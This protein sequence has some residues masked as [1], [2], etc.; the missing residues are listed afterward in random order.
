MPITLALLLSAIATGLIGVIVGFPALRLKG[1]YLAMATLG[2]GEMVRSFF[3]NLP[4]TGGSGGF[5]GMK[6]VSVGYMWMWA[7]AS[8]PQCSCWRARASGS[9]CAPSMTTKRRQTSSDS[10]SRAEGRCLRVRRGNR[11]DCRWPLRPSSSL[12]RAGNFGFERSIELVIAVILGGSTV[13][14][15][16]LV[17]GAIVVLLPEYLRF[18]AQWR[19]AAFGD[20]SRARAVDTSAGPHRQAGA[21]VVH[22]LGEGLTPWRPSATASSAPLLEVD[23]VTRRFGGVTAL[24][25]VSLSVPEGRIVG[26]IG[27]NGAGKTTVFNVI[28]GAYPPS[29]GDVRFLG[30]SLRGRPPSHRPRRRRAH[31]PELALFPSMTVLEHLI[32]AQQQA[33]VLGALL[34]VRLGDRKVLDRAEEVLAFFGLDEHRNRLARELPY[35][36]QRKVEMARASVCGRGCFSSTSPSPA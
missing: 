11:R 29:D 16:A 34:P 23:R 5:H 1:I 18:L 28:T 12:Y 2:F 27:P 17:G 20:A 14:P 30:V 7:A 25:D 15:G 22:A 4:Y 6:L 3:L 13:A 21:A 32:V 36:L 9:S 19:L 26:V 24:N 10:T 33:G 35:G 8:W 31:L